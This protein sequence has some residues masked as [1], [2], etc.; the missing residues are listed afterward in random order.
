MQCFSTET[1][2]SDVTRRNRAERL[3]PATESIEKL[4]QSGSL[5]AAEQA[6]QILR[7]MEAQDDWKHRDAYIKVLQCYIRHNQ[8][9][10]AHHLLLTMKQT[11]PLQGF[12]LV[13]NAW[14]QQNQVPKAHEL[15]DYY[16]S[17]GIAVTLCFNTLISAYVKQNKRVVHLLHTMNDYARNGHPEAKPDKVTMTSIMQFLA[18]RG[19]AREAQALLERMWTSSDTDMQPD[20]VTYSL[21]FTAYANAHHCMPNQAYA[22]LQTIKERYEQCEALSMKPNTVV[23]NSFLT[24]L[25][26]AGDGER[27]EQVLQEMMASPDLQPDA[28]TYGTVLQAWK[29]ASR[30]DRAEALLRRIS[31]P[32]RLCFSITIAALAKQ[33][34]AKRAQAIFQCMLSQNLNPNT[35]IYTALMNA[36]ANCKDDPDAFEHA[37]GVLREMGKRKDVVIDTAV[38]NTFLKAIENASS[39]ENKTKAVRSVLQ[40]MKEMGRKSQPN[41][42]TFRQAIQAV[43]ATTGDAD[44]QKEAL[45]EAMLMYQDRKSLPPNQQA[46]MKL[47]TAMLEACGKLSPKGVHGD[48]IVE[49]VF[50]ACCQEGVVTSLHTMLL[51]KAASDELLKRIFKT[52]TLDPQIFHSFPKSW[53][54]NR[55][56]KQRRGGKK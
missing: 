11:P 18:R 10:R 14:I 8:V 43:A 25:A 54:R 49:Q 26:N 5:H 23:Y 39:L 2:E 55:Q 16:M 51:Q 4:C 15:L 32:D 17:R 44:A 31:N 22:L 34:Q 52:D 21:V 13:A 12:C 29:N 48:E 36:W 46:Y 33:G 40:R 47:H 30:G 3:A 28:I 6:E 1:I 38:W 24:V 41:S 9:D 45:H 42:L 27:A 35:A 56:G 50:C 37:K 7:D 20:A 53:S 19:D